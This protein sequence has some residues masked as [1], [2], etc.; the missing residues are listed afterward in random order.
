MI[1][2]V[3]VQRQVPAAR[4]RAAATT[5]LLLL[6]VFISSGCGATEEKHSSRPAST[7]PDVSAAT[8]APETTT[9]TAS[10]PSPRFRSCDPNI[11]ARVGTTSCG[12]ATNAFYEYFVSGKSRRISVYSPA[13]KSSFKTTCRVRY[14][15]DVIVCRTDD[16]GIV[17]F[18]QSAI[19]AY[20]QSQADAYAKTADLG[21]SNNDSSGS[22][23][24]A[25]APDS[26][27]GSGGG[28]GKVCYPAF[29]IPAVTIP[30]TTIPAM[31]IN[32]VRYPAQHYPA[33]HYPAKTYP[34]HRYPGQC[35]HVPKA[36]EPSNTTVLDDSAYSN[37]DPSYSPTLTRRYRSAAGGS[38]SYPDPTA[39]GFG[40]SNGA[41]Y[42]KNQY[43]PPY[44]R[45]DGTTVSGYWRNSPSDGLPTC[46]VISC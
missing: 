44:V 1:A 19:D 36:F 37:V 41:G 27:S 12:F 33:Q 5:A 2:P 31:K 29:T 18:P 13:T 3:P 28:S 38:A 15:D 7:S 23:T 20:T 40:E 8:T 17:K 32:G 21:S 24:T 9:T 46:R 22:N 39:P 35:Y 11:Q 42:P 34:A 6:V 4:S 14:T 26:S 43:V 30:A 45:R 25:S 16:G 10:E